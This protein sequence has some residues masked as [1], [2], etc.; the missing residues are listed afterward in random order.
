VV[1]RRFNRARYNA[2]QIVTAFAAR[3]QDAVDLGTVRDELANVVHAALEPA[4]LSV[5]IK[6]PPP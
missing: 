6:D 4:H 1:D 3:L 2:D 5:W